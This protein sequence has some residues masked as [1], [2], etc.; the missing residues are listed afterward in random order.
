MIELSKLKTRKR[1]H[2]WQW[3]ASAIVILIAALLIQSMVTN[4]AFGWATVAQYLFNAQVLQGLLLSLELTVLC[5]AIGLILGTALAVMRMSSNRLLATLSWLY[6]WIFRSVPVLVQ[7]IL[8]Y[9]LGA[10]YPN[11]GFGIPFMPPFVEVPTNTVISALGASIL[12]LSLSQAAYSAEVIRGGI[13]SVSVGQSDAA[14][15]LGMTR[16]LTLMR[17][18]LPQALRVIVPPVGNEVVGMLKNTSLVSVIAMNDLFYTVEQIYANNYQTIPL[19]LVACFWYLV[20]VSLMS[21]GQ[22]Y[23]ERRFGRGFTR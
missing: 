12:G 2:P 21:F 13:L 10:L 11:L 14:E 19:L 3:L 6:I 20:V 8:W 23:L 9:N 7:L 5:M 22:S 4:A 17:I 15:A 18:V 1:L 16:G